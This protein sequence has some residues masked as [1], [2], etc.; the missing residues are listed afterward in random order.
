MKNSKKAKQK[1]KMHRSE[2]GKNQETKKKKFQ[3]I[4]FV[5]LFVFILFV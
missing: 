1:F 2:C 3:S 5:I 4:K